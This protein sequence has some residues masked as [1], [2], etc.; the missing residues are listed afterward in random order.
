MQSI[1][2]AEKWEYEL[3]KNF[4]FKFSAEYSN[5]ASLIH[6]NDYVGFFFAIE[7]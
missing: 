1:T 3:D 2:A 5:F 4:L 7:K 6:T